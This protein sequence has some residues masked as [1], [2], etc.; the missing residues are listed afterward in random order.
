MLTDLR[1]VADSIM[2]KVVSVEVNARRGME[3]QRV[4]GL[5]ALAGRWWKER[6]HGVPR[7]SIR[8]GVSV[9]GVQNES[10]DKARV[11]GQ[12]HGGRNGAQKLSG[13]TRIRG[14]G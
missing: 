13:N 9:K 7:K 6:H 10:R 2:R 1:A 4:P 3:P 12:R 5:L 8:K 11:E 14:E